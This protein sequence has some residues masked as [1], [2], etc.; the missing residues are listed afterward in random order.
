MNTNLRKARNK[1]KLGKFIKEHEADPPGDLD[2]FDA[3]LKSATQ[4]TGKEA[5]KA[6]SQDAS[7]D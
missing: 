5:P 7:D 3:I 6:S 2:K 4:G 1:G